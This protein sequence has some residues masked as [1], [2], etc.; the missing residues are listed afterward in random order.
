MNAKRND[1]GFTVPLEYYG[2][3]YCRLECPSLT[4]M[5]I[6]KTVEVL[7]LGEDLDVSQ[8][9]GAILQDQGYQIYLAPDVKTAVEELDNYNFD[10]VIVQAGRDSPDGLAAVRKAQELKS[11]PKIMVISGS[12]GKLF[13]VEAFE[14][15][16]DDY[17]AFPFSTTEFGRRVAALLGPELADRQIRDQSPA[18]KINAQALASL[19]HLMEEIRTAL[20]Q[21]TAS[22]QGLH[23]RE[24]A[25]LSNDGAK[26]LDE[27][28]E[29]LSQA[30]G[31]AWHFHHKTAHI[32]QMHGW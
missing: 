24:F 8:A 31:L 29:H 12:Q 17:L 18:E 19:N 4:P 11:P 32:S 20:L 7:I 22:L 2:A 3:S 13:P 23:R 14:S 21:A 1:S 5:E 30:V 6:V 27:M 9:M 10:L 25:H 15:D 28:M 26:K 16:A